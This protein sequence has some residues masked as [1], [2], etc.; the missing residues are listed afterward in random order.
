MFGGFA[1]VEFD[2]TD[3]LLLIQRRLISEA[4]VAQAV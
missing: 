1:S 2:P 4:A 3:V